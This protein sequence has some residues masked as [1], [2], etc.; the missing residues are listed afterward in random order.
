MFNLNQNCC[1]HINMV[2]LKNMHRNSSINIRKL[3]EQMEIILLK[4]LPH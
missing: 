4:L 3:I 1:T 2:A